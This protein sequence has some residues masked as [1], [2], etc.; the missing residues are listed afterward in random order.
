MEKIIIAVVV[1]FLM[2]VGCFFLS[3]MG[4]F[5][6]SIFEKKTPVGKK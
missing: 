3:G 5:E 1:I 4:T 6:G 2:L